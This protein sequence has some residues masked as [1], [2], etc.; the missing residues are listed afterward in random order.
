LFSLR[1]LFFSNERQKGKGVMEILGG[2]EGNYN[3]DILYEQRIY[4][5]L[6]GK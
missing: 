1:S 4:F 3:Q 5:Q 2:V 6:K